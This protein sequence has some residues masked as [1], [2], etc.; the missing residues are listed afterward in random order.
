LLT[1]FVVSV[2]LT[3]CSRSA[4]FIVDIQPDCGPPPQTVTLKDVNT[5]D[6][7]AV[8]HQTELGKYEF[9]M[10]PSVPF[11][12]VATWSNTNGTTAGWGPYDETDAKEGP[13]LLSGGGCD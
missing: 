6:T 13:I 10:I 5:G 7:I 9:E 2:I 8:G 4:G 3:G 12:I 1:V 11:E